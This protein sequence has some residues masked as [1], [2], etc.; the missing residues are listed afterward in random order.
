[1]KPGSAVE[2]TGAR[3]TRKTKPQVSLRFPLPLEIATRFPHSHRADDDC[4]LYQETNRK[5]KKG[6]PAQRQSELY[7]FRLILG[8]ENARRIRWQNAV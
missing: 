2:M 8:L 1:M 5:P 7:S 4:L 3:K 6:A